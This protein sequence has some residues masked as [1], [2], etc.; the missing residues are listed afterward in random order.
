MAKIKKRL[1]YTLPVDT[2]LTTKYYTEKLGV[3]EIALKNYDKVGRKLIIPE[4]VK[5]LTFKFER[6]RLKLSTQ[7]SNLTE[8]D[9]NCLLGTNFSTVN[10]PETVHHVFFLMPKLQENL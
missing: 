9:G 6:N 8:V 10:I 1:P 7:R 2:S 5:S 3:P 4:E